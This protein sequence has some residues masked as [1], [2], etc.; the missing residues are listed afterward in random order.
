[1]IQDVLKRED[2]SYLGEIRLLGCSVD[3]RG[4]LV[5]DMKTLVNISDWME[6]A[7]LF[8]QVQNL[9]RVAKD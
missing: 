7:A 5:S 9:I 4:M 1:M 8:M 2:S 3:S 6:G